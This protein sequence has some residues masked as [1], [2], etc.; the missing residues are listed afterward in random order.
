MDNPTIIAT[1]P[2]F[3]TDFDDFTASVARIGALSE[4]RAVPT[5][6]IARDKQF[7]REQMCKVAAA[8]AGAVHSWAT[9]ND[10][11]ELAAKVDFSYSDLLAGRDTGSAEKCQNVHKVAT[12][13]LDSLGQ[14][15]VSA[16]KLK[17]LQQKIDAYSGCLPK[18]RAAI[19]SNKTSTQQ[20]ESEFS[21]ADKLLHESLD[22]LAL[23]F[24]TSH[25]QFFQDWFN[26]RVI[27]DTA[28]TRPGEEGQ[29]PI[30]KA[31]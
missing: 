25:P 10:N 23:Q 18:P 5:K 20:L 24:E 8:S 9:K 28:A 30:A 1:I 4:K 17:A 12:E 11:L 13:S 19:G 22:K 27:V 29:P 16:A 7:C 3:V 26:A 15:G 14:H 21:A 31:A 2:A 6:G